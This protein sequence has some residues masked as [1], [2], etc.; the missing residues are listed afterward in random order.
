VFDGL[1]CEPISGYTQEEKKHELR[2]FS[3]MKNK[4]VLLAGHHYGSKRNE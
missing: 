2:Q 1:I 3:R 4:K